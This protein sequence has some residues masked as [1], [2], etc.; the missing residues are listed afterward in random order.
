MAREALQRAEHP[1]I[2]RIAEQIIAAQEREITQMNGWK[3]AWRQ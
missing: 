3:N 1:E 2:K